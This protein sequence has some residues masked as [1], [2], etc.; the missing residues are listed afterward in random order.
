MPLE[1]LTPSLAAKFQH[2][3]Y[4]DRE[5][6]DFVCYYNNEPKSALLDEHISKSSPDDSGILYY[7]KYLLMREMEFLCSRLKDY[8]VVNMF[9]L[10]ETSGMSSLPFTRELIEDKQM[11]VYC[12][13]QFTKKHC[14]NSIE[15]LKYHF[16]CSNMEEPTFKTDSIVANMELHSVQAEVKDI[17]KAD[18]GT[19][20]FLLL[21]SYLGN[22]LQPNI[23][24][25]NIYDSMLHG[26][27]FVLQQRLFKPG[28]ESALI[29]DYQTWLNKPGNFR[30]TKQIAS[31]LNP[32]YHLNVLWDELDHS[33]KV[34]V[35]TG[36][37]T[38]LAGI[39]LGKDENI[40]LFRSTSFVDETLQ[41]MLEAVGFDIISVAYDKNMDSN[42]L[43]F[44][45][46]N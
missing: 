32:D 13:V 2:T 33:I 39:D 21:N 12:P 22:S 40:T 24:L 38:N 28:I 6:P 35:K 11:G 18:G 19:N 14:K 9:D 10:Q 16:R 5:M 7:E 25:K 15:N 26:D 8:E 4:N 17:G 31:Y 36:L 41:G 23:V 27:Y 20:L 46:K 29:M 3:L 42:A 1:W 30:I 44:C 45:K 37:Y 34:K 43:Y